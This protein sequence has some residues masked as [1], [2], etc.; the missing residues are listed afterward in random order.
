MRTSTILNLGNNEKQPQS[1]FFHR[2]RHRRL[3]STYL[4]APNRF[5]AL[6]V[7][8]SEL[9][10]F[11]APNLSLPRIF[12]P[13][14]FFGPHWQFSLVLFFL[15]PRAVFSYPRHYFWHVALRALHDL[16]QSRALLLN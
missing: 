13:I 2:T 10:L 9:F 14:P 3:F 8:W 5:C 16:R 1:I 4:I 7:L 11:V 6:T 12:E 15:E